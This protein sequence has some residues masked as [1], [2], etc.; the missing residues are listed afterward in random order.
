MKS[1]FDYFL[2]WWL[3]TGRYGWSKLHRRL[4]ERRYLGTVLPAVSSLQEI[5]TSLQQVKW[6]MDG[7]LHLFDCI[8]YPQV[9]WAKKKDDCDG[10]ASLAAELLYRWEPNCAPV[11]LTALLR[12]VPARHTVCAFNAPQGGLCFFDNDSLRCGNYQSYD[13][14][15]AELSQNAKRLLCRDARKPLSLDMLEFHIM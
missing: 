13:K 4:F 6:T 11:L 8:S 2:V 3:R 9:T 1:V 5:G 10:F 12:P 15:A 14:I 7:H